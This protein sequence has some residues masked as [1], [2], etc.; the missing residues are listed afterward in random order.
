MCGAHA[1]Y[2]HKNEQI[3]TILRPPS[4]DSLH[5]LPI[6]FWQ[7]DRMRVATPRSISSLVMLLTAACGDVN[8]MKTQAVERSFAE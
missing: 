7:A 8:N 6:S 1:F 5:M 3:I 4:R 2:G